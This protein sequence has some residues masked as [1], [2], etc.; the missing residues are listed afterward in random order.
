MVNRKAVYRVRKLKRWLVHQRPCTPRRSACRVT[1]PG[2]WHKNKYIYHEKFHDA[3]FSVF[4]DRTAC[5]IYNMLFIQ[6][7]YENIRTSSG[8]NGVKCA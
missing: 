1:A 8:F 4:F 7:I 6:R 5:D 2:T 3:I